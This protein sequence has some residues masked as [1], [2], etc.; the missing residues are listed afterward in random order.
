[1]LAYIADELLWTPGI[2]QGAR[3]YSA[4]IILHGLDP[5]LELTDGSSGIGGD[6]LSTESCCYFAAA[7]LQGR[8]VDDTFCPPSILRLIWSLKPSCACCSD[9]WPAHQLQQR[10]LGRRRLPICEE[11]LILL[12][13]EAECESHSCQQKATQVRRRIEKIW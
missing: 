13:Q 1:L 9:L 4:R 12:E 3:S 5:A 6:I 7:A 2:S 8:F 11:M 10:R